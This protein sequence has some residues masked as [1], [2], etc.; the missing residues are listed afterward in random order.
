[1]LCRIAQT[2]ASAGSRL[3]LLTKETPELKK[4]L[5][6]APADWVKPFPTNREALDHLTKNA[7]ALLVSYTETIAEMP[8]VATSYPSK[9]VEY[10]HLG[11]PCVIVA[12]KGSAIEG[13]AK[14]ENYPFAFEPHQLD[15]LKNWAESLPDRERWQQF[16]RSTQVLARG[17]FS[18]EALQAQLE[19]GLVRKP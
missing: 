18:P 1:L 17:L 14:R 2:L 4:F 6:E 13:C 19:D 9:F 15:A 7:S 10:A 5:A 16:A 3:V 12:P 11:L 8:W